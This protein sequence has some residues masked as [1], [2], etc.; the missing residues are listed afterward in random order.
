M[1]RAEQDYQQSMY[2]S[3]NA[4]SLTDAIAKLKADFKITSDVVAKDIFNELRS[5]ERETF[6]KTSEYKASQT[7]TT[8]AE[9][10]NFEEVPGKC[11]K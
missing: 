4:M 10:S 5:Q 7:Q 2:G 6:Y 9:F 8:R 11:S 1:A 3:W